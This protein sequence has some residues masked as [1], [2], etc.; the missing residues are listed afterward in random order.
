MAA[1]S[2]ASSSP[3]FGLS[4]HRLPSP[5]SL[6]GALPSG[7]GMRG[8]EPPAGT[9]APGRKAE[10]PER[11]LKHGGPLWDWKGSGAGVLLHVLHSGCGN[12]VGLSR[13]NPASRLRGPQ[14]PELQALFLAGGAGDRSPHAHCH[15]Y[16]TSSCRIQQDGR[17]GALGP[18]P[19]P[20]LSSEPT[21]KTPLLTP[22]DQL[23]TPSPA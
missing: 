10:P 11:Q 2:R 15:G 3:R 12:L 14:K 18:A 6:Q 17:Q 16:R 13:A 23:A 20:Q 21:G 7:G 1:A 4:Q 5:F 9:G 22:R 8:W 19:W